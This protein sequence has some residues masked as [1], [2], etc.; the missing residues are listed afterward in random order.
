MIS[1]PKKKIM[2]KLRGKFS[3]TRQKFAE[4]ILDKFWGA[5]FHEQSQKWMKY[6]EHDEHVDVL[7]AAVNFSFTR[8]TSVQ[9]HGYCFCDHY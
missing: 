1:Q 5:H 9:R 2:I 4:V 8:E 7:K 6:F 3:K